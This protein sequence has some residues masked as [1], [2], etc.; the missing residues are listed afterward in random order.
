MC[1]VQLWVFSLWV[2]R[3]V[4]GNF[5]WCLNPKLLPW[6]FQPKSMNFSSVNSGVV[7]LDFMLRV[8]KSILQDITTPTFQPQRFGK[9]LAE[10]SWVEA[11]HVLQPF[12]HTIVSQIEDPVRLFSFLLF[13]H[14][15]CHIWVYMFNSFLRKKLVCI[16]FRDIFFSY[17]PNKKACK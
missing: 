4:G 1:I 2:L 13:P 12:D 14:P 9:F 8:G 6:N 16:L 15:V 11:W 3:A 10:T 17:K 7:K 5:D